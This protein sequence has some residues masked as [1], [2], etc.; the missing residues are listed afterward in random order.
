M[1]KK[2]KKKCENMKKETIASLLAIVVIVTVV[3]FVGCVKETPIV[4]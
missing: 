4:Y 2:I 1:D 3:M